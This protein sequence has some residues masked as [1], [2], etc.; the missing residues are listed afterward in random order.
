MSYFPL[1]MPV[2]GNG[3]ES[4]T[5]VPF[6]GGKVYTYAAGTSTPL[7]TK[8]DSTGAVSNANP[9]ILDSAG[10]A[11]MW[12]ADGVSYKIILKDSNDVTIWTADGVS[13][14]QIAAP[15]AA[16][17]IP[18]GGVIMYGGTAAPSGYLLCDGSP[19]SRATYSD[20]FT[21]IGI[22]YGP[23]NG[24][25]TF[26]LPDMRQ[27]FPM[28]KAT[29]GTGATLGVTG[30]T[31]DHTHTG[32][33]HTHDPGTL[34]A[35]GGAHTHTT[36][37]PSATADVQLGAGEDAAGPLHTHDIASS[38]AHTH[39]FAGLTGS[40]GTGATGTANPPFQTFNMVIKY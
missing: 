12:I 7:A 40:S 18:V 3:G 9:T 23:G 2:W 24:V 13:V 39:T 6:P 11:S 34:A 1:P 30:G 4:T 36:G 19:V 15:P 29:A 20:L 38:G 28:G 26:N 33:A 17:N 32:V 37:P 14:P 31:I 22:A 25:T 16:S 8:T 10:R 5:G 21:A 35:A 27:R